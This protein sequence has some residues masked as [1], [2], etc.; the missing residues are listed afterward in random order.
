MLRNSK[1]GIKYI[2]R[3]HEIDDLDTIRVVMYTPSMETVIEQTANERELIDKAGGDPNSAA[4]EMVIF[5]NSTKSMFDISAAF[6][7]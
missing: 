1:C 7:A 6:K 2:Y 3:G 4:N 5:S